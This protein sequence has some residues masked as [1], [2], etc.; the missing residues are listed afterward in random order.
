MLDRDED[1]LLSPSTLVRLSFGDADGLS[2]VFAGGEREGVRSWFGC[3]MF[4][5][6]SC[7]D[8]L[9][10]NVMSTGRL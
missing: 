1:K 8:L 5:K 4:P 7:V 9:L 10:P 3:K 6:G 2:G